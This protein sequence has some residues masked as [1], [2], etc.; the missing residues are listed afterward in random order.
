MGRRIVAAT[1]ACSAA[2]C[3]SGLTGIAG[4]A[5]SGLT[6]DP[7]IDQYIEQIPTPSGGKPTNQGGGAR[8]RS[9]L[10]RGAVSALADAGG[11]RFAAVVS[12]VVTPTVKVK[13]T[14]DGT[15]SGGKTLS[16]AQIE[17][18]SR[19]PDRAGTLATALGGG[20]GGLGPV[21]PIAL[22]GSVLGAIA[23]AASRFGRPGS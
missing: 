14:A 22:I 2:I 17:K 7:W 19:S 13:A 16:V 8:S 10:G 5:Q 18:D 4:A 12:A 9:G 15:G 3:L 20:G 6:G 1:A 21:L 11:D 23:L